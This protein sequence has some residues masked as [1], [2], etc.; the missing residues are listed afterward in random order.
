MRRRLKDSAA[1]TRARIKTGTLRDV[2]AVAGYVKDDADETWIV[3]GIV[4]HPATRR[5]IARPVLDA[6]IEW[7]ALSRERAGSRP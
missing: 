7:V 1:A 5:Q 2:S 6:L 3:V 4:N